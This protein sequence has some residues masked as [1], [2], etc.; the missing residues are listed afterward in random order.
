MTTI[1]LRSNTPG[2]LTNAQLDTNF[3]NLNND[4]V[5][6]S[7][8]NSLLNAGSVESTAVMRDDA[9][10]ISARAF[11]STVSNSTSISGGLA[12]RVGTTDTTNAIQFCTDKAAIKTYLGVDKPTSN[13]TDTTTISGGLAYRVSATDNSN[14]IQFCT[15]TTAIKTYLGL[16]SVGSTIVIT[17]DNS[18]NATRYIAWGEATSGEATGFSVSS[19]KLW[20]NPS[21]GTLAATSFN[22]LSDANLKENVRG[23]TGA[24]AKVE[25][26]RGVEFNWADSG[27]QSYGV[28]A[29]EMESILPAIVETADTGVKSVNYAAIIGFL[30]EAIKEL[31]AEILSLKHK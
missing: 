1:V 20:F 31:R 7:Y 27:T 12:Y 26:F 25:Q 11:K 24:L 10:N 15:D 8:L 6:V 16:D 28:I 18:T 22:S 3:T 30:I 5:E 9:G 21:S 29:Q 4:K 19:N 13:V 2:G 14:A 23:I 17:D